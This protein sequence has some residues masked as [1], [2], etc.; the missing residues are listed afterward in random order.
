MLAVIATGLLKFTCCHPEALSPVKTALASRVPLLV[1]RF[2]TCV[3][4]L[5]ALL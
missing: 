1:H 5:A 2:P 3:P 4:V